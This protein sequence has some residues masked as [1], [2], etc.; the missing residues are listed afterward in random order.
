M[1]YWKGKSPFKNSESDHHRGNST[2]DATYNVR[3]RDKKMTRA[4]EA[5]GLKAES[6]ECGESTKDSG[7][8]KK[9]CLVRCRA[10]C[11][12]SRD[13]ANRETSNEI[14]QE[15]GRGQFE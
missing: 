8:D 14:Y 10:S 12:K 9:P 15:C 11:A 4:E 7:D 3:T 1:S 2:D 6:G 5:R 13:D